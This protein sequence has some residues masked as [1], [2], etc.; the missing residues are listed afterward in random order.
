MVLFLK[1]STWYY[2]NLP[3]YPFS[4]IYVGSWLCFNLITWFFKVLNTHAKISN[5]SYRIWYK[6]DEGTRISVKTSVGETEKATVF[7]SI[8]QGSVGAALV[9]ALNIGVAIKETFTDQYIANIGQLPLN[10]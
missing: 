9:S 8:G 3:P 4:P 1:L 2:N 7:D 5:K 6:L 10:T